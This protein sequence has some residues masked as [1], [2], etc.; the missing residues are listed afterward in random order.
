LFGPLKSFEHTKVYDVAAAA[1]LIGFFGWG[2]SRDL[3]MLAQ[4]LAVLK[5]DGFELVALT[6]ALG[7]GLSLAFAGL[8]IV[9]VFIRTLPIKKSSGIV[10]RAVALIGAFGGLSML[11]LPPS[12]LPLWLDTVS[13]A[14]IF[15]GMCG[16][17]ISFAW[18]RRSFSVL[19]QARCL[20]TSGPY[21]LVR[22]PVYLFEEI[23]FFGVML[24]FAQPWALLIFATQLC[25]QLARIP[26]EERVLADAFPAYAEYSAQTARLI[27]GIY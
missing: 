5:N 21:A 27:P 1:P 6:E 24:Q 12:A 23:I 7:V 26:F 16:L 11:R 15:F 2:L 10:P 20:V 17:L 4:H 18:L 22:H 19:P 25:F 3:P 14:I 9:L 8:L 13:F